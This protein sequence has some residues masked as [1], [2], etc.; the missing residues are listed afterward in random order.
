MLAFPGWDS[1][2]QL[3]THEV[4]ALTNYFLIQ[5]SNDKPLKKHNFNVRKEKAVIRQNSQYNVTK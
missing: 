3:Q 4:D 2:P 5:E 1:E